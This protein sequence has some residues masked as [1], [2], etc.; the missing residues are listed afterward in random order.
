MLTTQTS[1]A[2]RFFFA[3]RKLPDRFVASE[4]PIRKINATP[5][6]MGRKAAKIAKKKVCSADH[7]VKLYLTTSAC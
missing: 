6:S 7:R 1:V 5:L 3:F 2:S 4:P